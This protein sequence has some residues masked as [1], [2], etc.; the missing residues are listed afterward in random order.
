[1]DVVRSES[2]AGTKVQFVLS[3][4][5]H[6]LTEP[7]RF[8]GSVVASE[9]VIVGD[10]GA[11]IYLPM[12]SK[13]RQLSTHT[14]GAPV[15]AALR[16]Q[17]GSTQK[18]QLQ[19]IVFQG[20]ASSEGVAAVVVEGGEFEM[21]N[22]TVRDVQG[23]R[24]LHASGGVSTIR[25]SRFENNTGGAL[26]ASSGSKVFI[27]D[28]LLV[29]N[30]AVTN[31][32]ALAVT[33]SL[34]EVTVVATRIERNSAEKQGGGLHV[35]AGSVVL[36]HR[37]VLEQNTAPEGAAVHLSGGRTVYALP[38]PSGRWVN[39]ALEAEIPSVSP[40]LHTLAAPQR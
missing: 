38:A 31:G 37:T 27:R 17:L 35:A 34:T 4:G 26:K 21:H 11:V 19:G 10:E 8:D 9:V 2:A 23:A 6:A 29:N 28:S 30:R 24:A 14:R 39:T 20:G 25:S 18:I 16:I 40:G 15:R 7:M 22:C 36:A 33:G 32:G 1:M 12:V 3:S 13:Q 5:V